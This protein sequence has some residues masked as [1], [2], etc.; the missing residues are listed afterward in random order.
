[1]TPPPYKINSVI[2]PSAQ[3]IS[4]REG[5]HKLLVYAFSTGAELS[6]C[7][8]AQVRAKLSRTA[9]L[10]RPIQWYHCSQNA[11]RK[12]V[13]LLYCLSSFISGFF[14]LGFEPKPSPMFVFFSSRCGVSQIR[15]KRDIKQV[16]RKAA[17]LLQ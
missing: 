8:A 9:M 15:A 14:L 10:E 12:S 6:K 7:R 13:H 11:R 16:Y 17:N 3:L 2:N 5:K 4:G 1:M